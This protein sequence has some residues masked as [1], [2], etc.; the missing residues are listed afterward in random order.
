MNTL[1]FEDISTSC[2][3]KK[4]NG[5]DY[6]RQLILTLNNTQMHEIFRNSKIILTLLLS[7]LNKKC[8]VFI[9]S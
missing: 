5:G 3:V 2:F 8:I 9:N 4:G 6:K 1:N 7:D